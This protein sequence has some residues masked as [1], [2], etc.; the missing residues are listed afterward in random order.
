VRLEFTSFRDLRKR[1]RRTIGQLREERRLRREIDEVLSKGSSDFILPDFLIIGAPKC[2]TSWLQSALNQHPQVRMVPD[3]IEFFSSHI[4]RPLQWY[5]AHFK[6]LTTQ[7]GAKAAEPGQKLVIG[8]KS[9][10]YCGISTSRIK[11]VHRLLPDARLILMVRDPVKRHWSHAKRYFSKEKSQ[12]RGYRS[13]DSRQKLFEFFKRTRRF[14]EFS[15]IIESWTKVYPPECLLV[16]NQEEAFADPVGIFERALRHIGVEPDA[17]MKMKKVSRNTK[18]S[19]PVVPM[20]D[21]VKAYLEKMF[22]GERQSMAKV[23]KRHS[24]HA[25]SPPGAAQLD[26][27]A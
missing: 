10:G 1:Y 16:I 8:E 24:G 22:A 21:D 15:K 17:R 20:P 27:G 7:E 12:E 4:D 2:A 3:E 9:A 11:L 23:L 18:N 19:G 26:R 6:E 14:S 5:L 13:L 25:T